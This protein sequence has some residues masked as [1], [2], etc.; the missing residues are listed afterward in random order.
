MHD[1]VSMFHSC[2]R[3][4]HYWLLGG[5]PQPMSQHHAMCDHI[6]RTANTTPFYLQSKIKMEQL[7]LHDALR[8]CLSCLSILHF[9]WKSEVSLCEVGRLPSDTSMVDSIMPPASRSKRFISIYPRRHVTTRTH[10]PCAALV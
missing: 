10:C 8:L 1:V 6:P 5:L 2:V 3:V 9:C 7:A 4:C